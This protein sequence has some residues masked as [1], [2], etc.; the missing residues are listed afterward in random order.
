LQDFLAKSLAFD[1]PHCRVDFYV[2]GGKRIVFGELTFTGG[3]GC[4]KFYPQSF[5][6]ELGSYIELP[7][8]NR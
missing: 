1:F 8:A 6:D 3:N 5:C 7:E 4:N 2:L